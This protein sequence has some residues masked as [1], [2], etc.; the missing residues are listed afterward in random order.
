[1]SSGAITGPEREL[2]A[3]ELVARTRADAE[4]LLDALDKVKAASSAGDQKVAAGQAFTQLRNRA[5]DVRVSDLAHAL[6]NRADAYSDGFK[7]RCAWEIHN[8]VAD[9]VS[10]WPDP[11]TAQQP[12]AEIDTAVRPLLTQVVANA[13]MLSQYDD[14]KR[15][16][17]G[18]LTQLATGK[19]VDFNALFGAYIPEA[20]TRVQLLQE[21]DNDADFAGAVDAKSGLVYKA[22]RKRWQRVLTYISPLLFFFVAAGA[23]IGISAL[24]GVFGSGYPNQLWATSKPT[25]HEVFTW[26]KLL[27]PYL[28]VVAGATAHLA[29]ENVKQGQ[30]DVPIVATKS[31]LTWLNLRWLGL[32]M[33]YAPVIVV[34]VGLSVLGVGDKGHD[35]TL[36][37]AAGY[38]VDSVAGLILNRFDTS[39]SAYGQIVKFLPKSKASSSAP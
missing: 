22:S 36:W 26:H 9:A 35:L 8:H 19:S 39:S 28:L 20:A 30:A 27:G 12:V 11:S 24:H 31:L 15:M 13:T 18:Q 33:T 21:L 25:G 1:M 14:V 2:T 16:L 34:V 38:S 29:V 10:L 6:T 17:E 7:L 23:L 4:G 5:W 32:A 3:N 37:L